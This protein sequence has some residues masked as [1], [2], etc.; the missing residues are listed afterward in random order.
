M[1]KCTPNIRTPFCGEGDCKW[2]KDLPKEGQ[3]QQ[4]P[5]PSQGT[6][7][8][9]KF[10]ERKAMNI[11]YQLGDLYELP[12]DQRQATNDK[13]INFVLELLSVVSATERADERRKVVEEFEKNMATH[14]AVSVGSIVW[15]EEIEALKNITL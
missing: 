11:V 6:P 8:D 5:Q 7:P 9:S 13:A 4:E 15:N 2:P 12:V 3:R 14:G 1:C 10:L